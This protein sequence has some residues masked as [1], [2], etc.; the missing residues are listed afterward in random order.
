V[1]VIQDPVNRAAD[2]AQAAYFRAELVAE[3]Q[4]LLAGL[5]KRRA[6]IDRPTD[7]GGAN[8]LSR[9]AEA[10][11]RHLDYLIARLDRRFPDVGGSAD[12]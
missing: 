9:R 5:G 8:A 4:L 1:T 3:R 12:S 6:L 11:V 10:E 2:V 7:S